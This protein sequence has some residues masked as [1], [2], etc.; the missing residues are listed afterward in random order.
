[1]KNFTIFKKLAPNITGIPRKNENSAAAG[2]EQPISIAPRIV[3]P[4]R[5]VP[6]IIA[7]T[8]KQPISA[9]VWNEIC[10]TRSIGK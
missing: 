5:E 7:S 10:V 3:A 8:W 2:R 9:A 4:E 6:G 1:M